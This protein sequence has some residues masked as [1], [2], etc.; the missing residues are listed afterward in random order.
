MNLG[1]LALIGIVL[2]LVGVCTLLYD[3]SRRRN[4]N[5]PYPFPDAVTNLLD[6]TAVQRLTAKPSAKPASA[7]R[8]RYWPQVR[9]ALKQV[10]LP[11]RKPSAQPSTMRPDLLTRILL[12]IPTRALVTIML[13]SV[14]LIGMSVAVLATSTNLARR[15]EGTVLVAVAP[16][17]TTDSGTKSQNELAD[18]LRRSLTVAGMTNVI[19]YAT[20]TMPSDATHAEQERARLGA[21]LF[22][23]GDMGADGTITANLTLAPNFSAQRQSC[24]EYTAPD[25]GLLHLPA[26]STVHLSASSGSDPLVPLVMGLANMQLGN[27][28]AAADAAWGAQATIDDTG[29]S[30]QFARLVEAEARLAGG[31]TPGTLDTLGRLEQA[32]P[33]SAEALL[34]RSAAKFYLLDYGGATDD[35]EQILSDRSS[36]DIILASAYLVRGRARYAV[37]DL[38]R[39]LSDIDESLRLAPTNR[40]THLERAEVYYRQ[41][42]PSESAIELDSLLKSDPNA[43]AAYRLM[44]LVRLM[45]AQPEEALKP[46]ASARSLY[47]GWIGTLRTQEAQSNAAGDARRTTAATEGIVR[48]NR[49]LAGIALYEGMAYADIARGEP[50][51]TFL[52]GLWRGIRGEPATWERALARMQEAARL[53]PRRAD[54][55]LQMGSLFTQQGDFKSAAVT[56]QQAR[57]LDPSAAEPYMAL[58]RLQEAQ[59]QS[60]EAAATLEDLISH[61]P[62]NYSAYDAL[63]ALQT[64]RGDEAS[65]RDAIERAVQIAPQT[66]EDHLW[67]GKF[68]R[69]L[70]RPDEAEVDLRIAGEDPGVWEAHLVLGQL[71]LEAGRGPDA[72]VEFQLALAVQP[73]NETALLATGRLLVL[74]GKQEDARKLFERLTTV[75]PQNVDGHIALLELLISRG[76]TDAAVTEGKRAVAAG[77]ERADAHYFL[78]LAFDARG[79]WSNA[80]KEYAAAAERDQNYFQAFLSLSRSLFMEDKYSDAL[81]ATDHAMA[82]RPD[83]PQPYRWK[84]EAELALGDTDAALSALGTLLRL[85]S[86]D[87]TALAL[88]ARAY[89][90]KGDEASALDYAQQAVSAAPQNPAGRLALGDLYLSGSR[91]QDALETFGKVLDTGDA[92]SQS[93]AMVGEARAFAMMGQQD[94]AVQMFN[95]AAQKDSTAAEPYLYIG[96]L[97]VGA[98]QWDKALQSYRGAVQ[99]RPNW[100]LALYSLGRAYLQRKDLQN[101]Q[102]AFAKAV[103]YGPN[104]VEAWFGLG[105]AHRGQGHANEAIQALTKAT[106][107]NSTYSEAWLYL[108]LTYEETGRRQEAASSFDH[109]SNTASDDAV[110]QQA[111][112]GFERVR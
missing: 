110:K 98:G 18:Y 85:N 26:Q 32:E 70:G 81:A 52:G 27:F 17:A 78:G 10:R 71:L 106:E 80:S 55:P 77:G 73:N 21:D 45:L 99:L 2:L 79:D 112:Q 89:A 93:L 101:A 56:L 16:F 50:K 1:W 20:G 22:L 103:T 111:V 57:E 76:E 8:Q 88:T 23:W 13:L 15:P 4:A 94:K 43:A 68:L 54:I 91:P 35:A 46:L 36:P 37:G 5:S 69:T 39:A 53:D 11:A 100:S 62:R 41:A 24:Q 84:A 30:G 82:L 12:A 49:E 44:G 58:A 14:A 63:S 3:T 87:A 40:F 97:Y 19:V 74:A 33:L 95:S 38:T 65:A 86:G 109:A 90:S 25:L 47:T 92:H 61:S 67:H 42:K 6:D 75:S 96:N 48:L 9:Q 102:N 29:G 66:A 83:D 7:A 60:K 64:R 108:G 72:L 28:S 31:D 59:G 107:L 51:E 104:M 34:A 105:M